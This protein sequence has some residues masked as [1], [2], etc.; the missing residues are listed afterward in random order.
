M[1]GTDR[2]PLFGG[3]GGKLSERW[4]RDVEF[5][6][7]E[8]EQ[9]GVGITRHGDR[10]RHFRHACINHIVDINHADTMRCPRYVDQVGRSAISMRLLRSTQTQQYGHEH[11]YEEPG[12]AIWGHPHHML[13][14]RN[15][16]VVVSSILPQRPG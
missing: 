5:S 11:E 7:G 12:G 13:A 8:A 6:P 16:R 15:A 1:N 9:D 3:D 10:A 14:F 2:L 4:L